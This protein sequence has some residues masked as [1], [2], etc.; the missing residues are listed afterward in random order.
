M[1]DQP[2]TQSSLPSV[3][4]IVGVPLTNVDVADFVDG[5]P[6][7][8]AS[9]LQASV[10]FSNPSQTMPGVVVEDASSV[11]HVLANHTYD[12]TA[13]GT[14]PIQVTIKDVV[15]SLIMNNTATV[16]NA[17]A[18]LTLTPTAAPASA[19]EGSSQ[20]FTL[21]TFTSSNAAAVAA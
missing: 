18:T 17:A 10:Q 5:N 11:F 14:S 6:F 7:A 19:T 2:L 15:S 21:G 8:Q 16:S 1:L 4:A 9:D 3:K 12:G 20:V 13:G